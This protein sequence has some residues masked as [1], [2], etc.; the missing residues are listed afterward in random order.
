[1][2]VRFSLPTETIN[3][4]FCLAQLDLALLRE[5]NPDPQFGAAVGGH[6]LVRELAVEDLLRRVLG[7]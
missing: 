6:Q 4:A 1:M 3:S 7:E 2:I 5:R